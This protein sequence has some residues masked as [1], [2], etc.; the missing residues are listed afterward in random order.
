MLLRRHCATHETSYNG[1]GGLLWSRSDELHI[2]K[3]L[4]VLQR[5]LKHG[6][7]LLHKKSVGVQP[8]G[9]IQTTLSS[10]SSALLLHSTVHNIYSHHLHLRVPT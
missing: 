4:I 8:Q 2:T 6:Y 3:L 5:V 1:V 10:T 9:A 7:L